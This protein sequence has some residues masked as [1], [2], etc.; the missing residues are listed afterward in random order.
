MLRKIL[1]I[2]MV[3]GGGLMLWYFPYHHILNATDIGV[4]IFD[5]GLVLLAAGSVFAGVWLL[6]PGNKRK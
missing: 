5:G 4:W 1:P 3:I 2:V 6:L